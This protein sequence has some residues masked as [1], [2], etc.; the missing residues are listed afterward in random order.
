MACAVPVSAGVITPAAEGA[1]SPW[2]HRATLESHRVK[3]LAVPS[4]ESGI[5]IA[6]TFAG[7][8]ISCHVPS[9]FSNT[10]E[11]GVLWVAQPSELQCPIRALDIAG[12]VLVSGSDDMSLRVYRRQCGSWKHAPVQEAKLVRA[13][14][15]YIRCVRFMPR[16][17]G[18]V[19][20]PNDVPAFFS[21]SDDQTVRLFT[22]QAPVGGG[23]QPLQKQVMTGHSHY[24]MAAD[25]AVGAGTDVV[26]MI[27]SVSLD[28]SARVWDSVTGK[29]LAVCKGA[30]SRGINAV[31]VA[32]TGVVC[33]LSAV[34]RSQWLVATAADDCSVAL[35]RLE[36]ANR[37]QAMLFCLTSF[38]CHKNNVSAVLLHPLVAAAVSQ[39]TR[40][41]AFTAGEDCVVQALTIQHDTNASQ[42]GVTMCLE[43]LR[44]AP[45]RVWCLQ[46]TTTAPSSGGEK[47]VLV[48]GTDHGL[49]V[50]S[51]VK[52]AA[53]VPA[54]TR[55]PPVPVRLP[56]GGR[57][58]CKSSSGGST[59][60]GSITLEWRHTSMT[61]ALVQLAAAALTMCVALYF[62][63]RALIEYGAVVRD[64]Y[65]WGHI[66]GI[67]ALYGLP[68]FAL[69][70]MVC[71]LV[72]DLPTTL[73]VTLHISRRNG[74]GDALHATSSDHNP[75]VGV[76]TSEWST[77]WSTHWRRR[78]YDGRIRW[79]LGTGRGMVK[80]LAFGVC[81]AAAPMDAICEMDINV[82]NRHHF[83]PREGDV[84]SCGGQH[85]LRESM[86][87]PFRCG[88]P[89]PPVL[90]TALG[91]VASLFRC[92]TEFSEE[93]NRLSTILSMQEF[94]DIIFTD[95]Q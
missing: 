11:L 88:A 54:V 89:V 83:V 5:V 23:H 36:F 19:T 60:S 25:W 64:N 9:A 22:W 70:P 69:V 66:L 91:H 86:I 73:C 26:P 76:V 40:I 29:S 38:T 90:V 57:V 20:T 77:L 12:D 33:D 16:C 94:G 52:T 44:C 56:L 95:I 72:Y 93:W 81:V 10:P 17:G 30:H 34:S 53:A 59:A 45:A 35:L 68:I 63:V 15:D 7:T 6:G 2:F 27:V 50:V 55:A 47:L 13:H 48:V 43:P 46:T 4:D 74:T 92:Q 62:Q 18:S 67:M 78:P 39:E 65:Q 58:I 51:N 3:S 49:A 80:P 61:S 79:T 31:S 1:S 32:F 37:N 87:I 71:S 14:L 8:L 24:V 84:C 21:C 75:F 85:A 42:C 82:K 28:Q 41:D